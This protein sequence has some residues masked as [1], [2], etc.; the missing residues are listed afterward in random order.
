MPSSSRSSPSTNN[1]DPANLLHL[2]IARQAASTPRYVFEQTVLTAFGWIPTLVG[3]GIR[4]LAYRL[5]LKMDGLAAIENSVRLRF[6]SNIRLGRGVYLDEG[7]YLHATPQGIEIGANTYIMHHAELHVY[8]FRNLPHAWIK[9]GS[10]C[11]ISEF[12]VL[13]GQG[14]IT[15]GNNVYTAPHVQM[16]AVDHVYSD[17]YRPII[18][19]GITAEGIV[20]E[21]N[22]WIG[23]GAILL[24]GIVVGNGAVVAA[25]AVV[26]HDVPA[27]TLV[28]GV[29]ARIIKSIVASSEPVPV[30][31]YMGND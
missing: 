15:I 23:A 8:N 24:D 28:G 9:I 27:H 3:I 4:A 7:V 14:G 29:P 1:T 18:S 2:Y 17:P 26:T 21:D 25:G 13:R 11:L 22:A 10:N 20:V 5:I 19:Q 31:V 6:A 30:P 12:N 16:L